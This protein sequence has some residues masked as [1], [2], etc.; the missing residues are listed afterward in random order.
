MK[1]G[2]FSSHVYK[3]YNKNFLWSCRYRQEKWR[4]KKKERL[5]CQMCLK[6]NQS[7]LLKKRKKNKCIM[8]GKVKRSSNLFTLYLFWQ[9]DTQKIERQVN[10]CIVYHETREKKKEKPESDRRTVDPQKKRIKN[11]R[12]LRAK[13]RSHHKSC[14]QDLWEQFI[15]YCVGG[16][17]VKIERKNL[18]ALLTVR[19]LQRTSESEMDRLLSFSFLDLRSIQLL[20]LPL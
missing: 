3:N 20:G 13:K 18:R 4:P 5:T 8:T 12:K 15:P 16:D 9:I 14:S 17:G 6:R 2:I 1:L 10:A 19:L 11:R 7:F